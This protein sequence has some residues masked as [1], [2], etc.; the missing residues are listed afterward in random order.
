[1][2]IRRAKRVQIPHDIIFCEALSWAA[3]GVLIYAISKDLPVTEDLIRT[4]QSGVCTASG[5]RPVGRDLAK[6]LINEIVGAG[7]GAY[8]PG[9]AVYFKQ[10][11]SPELR[12]QVFERDGHSCVECGSNK[13]LCADHVIP[14][15]LG[16]QATLENLQ[17]MCRPCNS[18]KGVKING[19]AQ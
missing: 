5:S 4:Y 11:I 6:S 13:R 17:T 10:R 3:R 9:G 8:A 2:S 15:R 12:Q 1:M 18:E 16:G 19:G 14:E 7:F